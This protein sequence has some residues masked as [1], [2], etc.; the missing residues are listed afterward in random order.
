[1]GFNAGD[2]VRFSAIDS[3]GTDDVV[4]IDEESN[5]MRPGVFI[6]R[7]DGSPL[8]GGCSNGAGKALPFLHIHRLVAYLQ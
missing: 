1:M 3:S 7:V 5:V 2:E 6:Y 4:D 8:P